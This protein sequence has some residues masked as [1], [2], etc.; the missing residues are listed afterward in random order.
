[1]AA[2]QT[3]SVR[4]SLIPWIWPMASAFSLVLGKPIGRVGV[5]SASS[6]GRQRRYRSFPAGLRIPCWL[7][8]WMVSAIGVIGVH[9]AL[10]VDD[11]ARERQFVA[12]L[13]VTEIFGNG[14]VSLSLGKG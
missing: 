6:D 8:S 4:L 14:L 3:F 9:R 2:F 12:G 13:N 11:E 5:Y 1:M 10:P 7:S